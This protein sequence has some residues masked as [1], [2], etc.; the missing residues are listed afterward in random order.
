MAALLLLYAAHPIAG[1]VTFLALLFMTAAS[2]WRKAP[3]ARPT[4]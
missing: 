1:W 3:P 2:V 4:P